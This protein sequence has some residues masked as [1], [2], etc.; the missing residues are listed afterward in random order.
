[1]IVSALHHKFVTTWAA[2]AVVCLLPGLVMA[3]EG[4]RGAIWASKDAVI[5]LEATN[6]GAL[7]DRVL[8][9]KFQSYLSSIPTYA[10]YIKGDGFRQQKAGVDFVAN[11]L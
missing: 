6:P 5:Y 9:P 8:E 2:I 1:M 11:L 4:P 3:A 10:K 7:L